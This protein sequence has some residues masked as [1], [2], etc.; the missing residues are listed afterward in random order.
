M[1]STPRSPVPASMHLLAAQAKLAR[2]ESAGASILHVQ[3]FPF[4]LDPGDA[5]DRSLV[6]RGVLAT[7]PFGPFCRVAGARSTTQPFGTPRDMIIESENIF[8]Q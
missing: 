8:P 4:G 5:R 2:F 6:G 3:T 7:S 1:G